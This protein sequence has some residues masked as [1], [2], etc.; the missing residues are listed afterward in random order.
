MKLNTM[1]TIQELIDAAL[2]EKQERQSNYQLILDKEKQIEQLQAEIAEL[3]GNLKEGY[4]L[5]A[6]SDLQREIYE[7]WDKLQNTDDRFF[8]E[9]YTPQKLK[10]PPPSTPEHVLEP[11]ER[12]L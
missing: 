1:K 11:H 7:Q 3:R 12:H 5:K 2:A 4:E 9:N 6:I 8:P 10:D